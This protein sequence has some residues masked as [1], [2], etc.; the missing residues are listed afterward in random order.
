M[1]LYGDLYNMMI[2]SVHI[3]RHKHSMYSS[4]RALGDFPGT[5][6]GIFLCE[7]RGLEQPIVSGEEKLERLFHRVPKH[8]KTTGI[9]WCR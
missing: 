5:L 7:S 1:E 9:I 6:Q 3:D 2:D 8:N 4:P